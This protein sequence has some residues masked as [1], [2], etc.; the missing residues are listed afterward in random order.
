MPTLYVFRHGQTDFNRD[1]IHCGHL[2]G[3]LTKEGIEQAK[4]IGQLLTKV[5]FE[6]AF[7]SRLSRSKDTLKY[8]LQGHQEK[9]K[10]ITDDRIIER[11]Y[12]FL[13][14]QKHQDVIDKYGQEQWLKWRRGFFDRIP[15][16]ESFVDVKIRVS[17]FIKDLI[18]KYGDQ[19]INIAI[20]AHGNSIR[21]IR[22]IL[23]NTTTDEA[24]T[25]SIPYDKFFK[26]QL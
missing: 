16:G 8:V 1:K 20:S 14:G 10:I 18:I 24:E 5:K 4:Q 12:G 19:D 26:Y 25:W 15:Q 7:Q 17:D 22:H 13:S 2:N 9:I 11:N 3:K 23:E 6:L 21:L